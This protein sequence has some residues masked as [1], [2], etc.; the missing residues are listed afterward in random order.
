[1]K[2]VNLNINE[3]KNTSLKK[4]YQMVW[5]KYLKI[6]MKEILIHKI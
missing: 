5:I 1:M 3:D 6:I 2:E 4:Y